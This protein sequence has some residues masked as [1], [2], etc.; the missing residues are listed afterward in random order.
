MEEWKDIVGYEGLYQVSNMG[1]V[2]SLER[3]VIVGNM[4]GVRFVNERILKGRPNHDGYLRVAFRNKG[5]LIDYRIHTL[6]A[7]HFISNENKYCE[8]NHIDKNVTNNTVDNLEWCTRQHNVVHSKGKRV[9]K[10]SQDNIVIDKFKSTV[11]ASKSVN[12]C[13]SGVAMVCRGERKLY[14]GFIWRY[15]V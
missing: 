2:K 11:E 9:S 5:K 4:G 8:I 6:V 7:L 13:S 14:K 10:I 3:M 15:D 12:G 1:R